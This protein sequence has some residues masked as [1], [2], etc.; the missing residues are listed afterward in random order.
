MAVDVDEVIASLSEK[1]RSKGMPTAIAAIVEYIDPEDGEE[2][3]WI[4]RD[5]KTPVWKHIGMTRC[6]VNDL[7]D[8]A[9]G[10]D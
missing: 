4:I 3:L 5:T 10:D 8:M 7:E 6:A 9:R 2:Y 1:V